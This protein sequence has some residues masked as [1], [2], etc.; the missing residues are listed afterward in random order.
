MSQPATHR[1]PLLPRFV[2]SLVVLGGGLVGS[3]ARGIIA[4]LA[5]APPGEFPLATL[6]VNLSGS[7]LL[8]LFLARRER[9]VAPRW[10]LRFWAIGA[11]GAFTTFSAFSLEVVHLIETGRL[12][13]ALGYV[14]ASTLGGLAAALAGDRL[15]SS[16][17]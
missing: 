3:T 12:A 7:F 16:S 10:S 8:G 9:A 14:L 5:P 2:E 4:A 13:T 17:R 1:R 15:G 11:L 6:I